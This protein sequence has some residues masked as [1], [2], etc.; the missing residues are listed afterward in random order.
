MYLCAII[1]ETELAEALTSA[2]SWCTRHS[3]E[4]TVKSQL[5]MEIAV[6]KK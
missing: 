3:K 4:V 1:Q 6:L 5:E 2:E